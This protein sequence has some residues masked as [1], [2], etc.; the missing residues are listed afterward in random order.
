V[1]SSNKIKRVD[2]KSEYLD[3]IISD[4]HSNITIRF[5]IERISVGAVEYMLPVFVIGSIDKS[6]VFFSMSYIIGGSIGSA[7][8]GQCDYEIEFNDA[9]D[10]T[11]K[12]KIEG[13]EMALRQ[14]YEEVVK[15][16]SMLF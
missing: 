2:H 16:S 14:K 7:V 1:L 15:L 3:S 8:S 10:A 13:D 9:I 12:G 4:D 5:R 11:E 6:R